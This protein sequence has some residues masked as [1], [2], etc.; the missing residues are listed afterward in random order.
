[1]RWLSTA[2]KTSDLKLSFTDI[3]AVTPSHGL[4]GQ[5]DLVAV[6]H[7]KQAV[8]K[9]HTAGARR[10]NRATLEA[11]FPSWTHSKQTSREDNMAHNSD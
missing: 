11:G 8:P 3:S 1:M 2:A 10:R 6:R 7:A 4:H 9:V 5:G